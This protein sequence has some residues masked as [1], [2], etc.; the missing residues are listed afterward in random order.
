VHPPSGA[1]APGAPICW[2]WLCCWCGGG[3]GAGEGGRLCMSGALW[4]VPLLLEALVLLLLLL[5]LLPW[6]MGCC[7][8]GSETVH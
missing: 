1:L 6:P 4:S 5:L 8:A 7:G 3:G 2:G